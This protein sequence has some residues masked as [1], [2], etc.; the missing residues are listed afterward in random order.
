MKI[1]IL[2]FL[3]IVYKILK[4]EYWPYRYYI[5][6][7]ILFLT[8]FTMDMITFTRIIR[9]LIICVILLIYKN[10][11]NYMDKKV[12]DFDIKYIHYLMWINILQNPILYLI[13]KWDL[14]IY[15]KIE[16]VIT[17][18]MK[19]RF[20]K[21][22][23]ISCFFNITIPIKILYIKF[24]KTID[25]INK[26]TFKE[27]MFNRIY[28]FMLGILI[29]SNIMQYIYQ[30]TGG[31]FN[32]IIY[33]YMIIYIFN[34]I[35]IFFIYFRSKLK[36][37]FRLL[38]INKIISKILI[39]KIYKDYID[40]FNI[41]EINNVYENKQKVSILG[42]YIKN[43]VMN[44]NENKIIY[45]DN[46][47]YKI[48]EQ[49]R[50]W[51]SFNVL[52]NKIKFTYISYKD[53]KTKAKIMSTK[54][55]NILDLLN[56]K[57]MFN[58]KYFYYATY[59]SAIDSFNF[60]GLIKAFE[61]VL[62]Y[63]YY[64][65][66]K[67]VKNEYDINNSYNIIDINEYEYIYKMYLLILKNILFYIWTYEYFILEDKNKLTKLYVIED[68]NLEFG[69]HIYPKDK[70]NYNPYDTFKPMI[71][72]VDIIYRLK[73]NKFDNFN[74]DAINENIYILSK[75]IGLLDLSS[76]NFLIYIELNSNCKLKDIVLLYKK[77]LELM[78]INTAYKNDL[79]LLKL[80]ISKEY[81]QE[82]KNII[83]IL[84]QEWE[85]DY[86]N[87]IFENR[88][89]FNELIKHCI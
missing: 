47:I 23:F 14:Y 59:F 82:L 48:P 19:N 65:I 33:L 4:M 18:Y 79:S 88:K 36:K 28:G 53:A 42:N 43:C 31:F 64:V 15:I 76:S 58:N 56:Y 2:N 69:Y 9:F 38:K 34:I 12:V 8:T 52:L 57:I 46:I 6:L 73:N 81:F 72:E 32:C 40:I 13:W 35:Y 68:I 49:W 86:K 55:Q 24:Y 51:I 78:C 45:L 7:Y 77:Y 11:Y 62:Y 80:E 27:F 17:T 71:G 60:M 20:L 41:I 50:I 22:F 67:G 44:L 25:V 29:F 37:D 1:K 84:Y 21:I 16:K 85:K 70:D 54:M 74:Y 87:N 75:L 39:Y 10:V 5:L 26:L 66:K 83:N 63:K 89:V 3:N 61:T 30:I